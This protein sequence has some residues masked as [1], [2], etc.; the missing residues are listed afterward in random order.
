MILKRHK[1]GHSDEKPFSCDVCGKRFLVK[2]Q[3]TSHMITHTGKK[4]FACDECEMRFPRPWQLRQHKGTHSGERPFPCSSC[5]KRFYTK[6]LRRQHERSHT[7]TTRKKCVS[8]TETVAES[9]VSLEKKGQT[10]D[11]GNNGWKDGFEELSEE[12]LVATKIPCDKSDTRDEVVNTHT[13]EQQICGTG[14]RPF[15]CDECGLRFA[16]KGHILL[17]LRRH[18]NLKRY[19]CDQ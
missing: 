13:M 4:P 14:V 7:G 17:H 16:Q 6:T 8:T 11:S 2:Q 15:I 1:L 12:A 18:L 10:S 19:S 3:V 5:P 9:I